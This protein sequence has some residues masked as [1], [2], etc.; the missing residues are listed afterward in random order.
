M[1]SFFL[2]SFL[3]LLILFL[4][5]IVK[6]AH[7]E[8]LENPNE[9]KKKHVTLKWL[10]KLPF[11]HEHVYRLLQRII[12]LYTHLPL[13]L[14][15]IMGTFFLCHPMLFMTAWHST[16]IILRVHFFL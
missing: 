5:A 9:E 1:P 2:F 16:A 3:N 13:S 10:C 11:Y 8:N 15:N 6:H 14:N 7:Y 4:T 12:T